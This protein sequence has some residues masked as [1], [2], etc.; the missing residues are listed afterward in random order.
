VI[1]LGYVIGSGGVATDPDKISWMLNWPTP[2][3]LKEVKGFLGVCGW[4]RR[5]IKDFA[6]T[7]CPST[8]F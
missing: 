3:N 1:Y 2:K 7:T 6:E 4:Y 5:F 8:P